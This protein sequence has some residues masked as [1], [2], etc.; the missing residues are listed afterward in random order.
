VSSGA[1]DE[2]TGRRTLDRER[3]LRAA[4][5]LADE[6]GLEGTTMRRLA[7]NLGVTAMALYKHVQNREAL[8]D[9]MVDTVIAQI[10]PIDPTLPLEDPADWQ[11]AVRRRI[12]AARSAILRH[13]WSTDA[14]ESRTG[15]SPTVLAYMDSLM[16]LLR[17]GGFSLE[18]L[19][20]AM[21]ALS[22]RM[23][24]FTREV[25]P[26]P[27]LPDDPAAQAIMLERFREQFPNIVA[28]ATGSAHA[29]TGCD[30]Q[31]EFEFALDLLVD[32]LERRRL[33]A[34]R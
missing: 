1:L 33:T 15:A 25:F 24:G 13:P 29:G 18:L 16:G 8:I 14:I 26:T 34:L 28:M 10:R 30:S 20:N 32:G 5:E 11:A 19:H 6:V 17:A 31:A 9:G 12:L 22:T 21:H 7:E 23:W 27:T 2:P 4:V 3:V